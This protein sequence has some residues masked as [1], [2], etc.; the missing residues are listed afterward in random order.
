[1]SD[2]IPG[3]S[4][5]IGSSADEGRMYPFD[6]PT[7][8]TDARDYLQNLEEAMAMPLYSWTSEEVVQKRMLVS[9]VQVIR[10]FAHP[11]AL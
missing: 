10:Q 8:L 9:T 11:N 7:T 1:M 3:T 2:A 6:V 4:S 5:G